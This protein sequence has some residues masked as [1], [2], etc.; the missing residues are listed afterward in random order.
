MPA[1]DTGDKFSQRVSLYRE[2]MTVSK[3]DKLVQIL[4]VYYEAPFRRAIG[5]VIVFN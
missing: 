5:M 4:L 1:V 2:E 3:E